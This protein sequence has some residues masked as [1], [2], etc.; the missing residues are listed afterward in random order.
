MSELFWNER[1]RGVV[2]TILFLLAAVSLSGC[3]GEGR[4]VYPERW[5]FVSRGLGRD[6]DVEYIRGI[7]ETAAAHGL[8]GMALTAGLDRLDLAGPDYFRRLAEVKAFCA[9]KGVEIVP[10]IFS[11][12]YGGSVLAHNPSLAAGLPVKD[13]LFVARGGRAV[14]VPDPAP[15]VSNG[16]FETSVGDSVPGFECIARPGEVMFVDRETASD[17]KASLRFENLAGNEGKIQVRQKVA[18]HPRRVYRVLVKLKTE[19]FAPA[20][21]FQVEIYGGDRKI[22]YYDPSLPPDNDWQEIVLG[23]NSWDCDSVE[24]RLGIP[25][26]KAEGRFWID[27]LRVEEVGLTNVLRRPGAP[28]T[29]RGESGTLY[30][31]GRDFEPVEDPDLDYV[32]GR[33]GPDIVLAADSRI[34]EGERLRV[35]W[36]HG[37]RSVE[38]KR[39]VTVC[40]SE[41]ELYDIWRTQ[42]RLMVEHLGV[43]KFFLDMDEVRA[44]G[45][46]M[47]CTERGLSMGEILGDCVR[48][49]FEI[50]REAEP[51]AEVYIW[52]DMLD[53]NHN[54]GP[55]WGEYYYH[56]PELY[57][58]SWENLPEELIIVCWWDEKRDLSLPF[59]SGRG[60]RT[61]AGSYYDADDLENVR[62]WL[63]SLDATPGAVGIMYTTWEDKYELLPEFGEMVTKRTDL[64]KESQ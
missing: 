58:G 6:S 13:A 18:V 25:W 60:F 17:G 19:G 32:F 9:E 52:S 8:N 61:F 55:T 1:K 11:A 7:V 49:Q 37:F 38:Q 43:K 15:A 26:G 47:A 31:E 27:D 50:L 51:E 14:H 59:F 10:V 29:V 16:S 42:A 63:T 46:C 3:A 22:N 34:S 64:A 28:L 21:R 12:G 62:L 53:P 30:E 36:Y 5:V 24:V 39:Q 57:T 2:G 44:G 35:S 54:A 33:T 4:K 48:K 23:F 45:T 40:M 56:V 20:R 41:P